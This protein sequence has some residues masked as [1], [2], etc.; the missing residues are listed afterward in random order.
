MPVVF[1]D[2]EPFESEDAYPPGTAFV[3]CDDAEIGSAAARWAAGYLRRH[4]VTRPAV[5]VINGVRYQQREL[6][7][8]QLLGS[9]MP[10]TQFITCCGQ[11]DR[12][13][14]REAAR[15]E[16]RRL[17]AAGKKL[18]AVFC[19][20]DEMALGVTDALLHA[21]HLPWARETVVAGV[22]GTPDARAQIEAGPSPLRATVA[23][24]PSKV[25]EAAVGLM[26]KMIRKEQVPIRTS[27]PVEILARD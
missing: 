1:V 16:L 9:E 21:S 15:T 27:V 19:T 7:F 24:E 25:A 26:E 17:E 22:D 4:H 10:G 23:Q 8:R 2:A 11:F 13:K 5:L 14:A 12:V 6:M 18:H 20:N 3:G